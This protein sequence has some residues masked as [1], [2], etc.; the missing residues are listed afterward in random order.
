MP[1]AL[2]AMVGLGMIS[3]AAHARGVQ[4][5]PQSALAA[6][7]APSAGP[8]GLPELS[9]VLEVQGKRPRATGQKPGPKKKQKDGWE[10]RPFVRPVA[11]VSIWGGSGRQTTSIATAGGEAGIVY[12]QVGRP[13]PRWRVTPRVRAQL[14]T[15]SS[16]IAGYHARVGAQAGP[17]WKHVGL[18]AGPDLYRDQ[19]IVDGVKLDPVNGLAMPVMGLGRLGPVGLH[20]GVEPSWFLSGE[21]PGVDWSE[22]DRFGFGDEFAYL[23]GAS[24]KVQKMVVGVQWRR[25]I[26]SAGEGTDWGFNAGFR[27]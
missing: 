17:W 14:Y 15:T 27:L 22:T 6:F 21:R 24:M 23:A 9:D 4:S 7:G 3:T 1:V 8:A 10:S 19:L 13:L 18:S 26:T 25:R 12:R 11:G 16:G 5:V 20:A 2:S